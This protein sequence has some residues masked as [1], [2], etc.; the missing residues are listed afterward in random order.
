MGIDIMN[1]MP[2]TDKSLT[3]NH[4][5]KAVTQHKLWTRNGLQEHIFT[6]LFSGLV[7]AQIWEDPCI[8]MEALQLRGD[9]DVI[10]IASGG[11]N[12]MSYLSTPLRS[13]TAVDLNAHHIALNELKKACATHFPS[14]RYIYDFFART[15]NPIN[16]QHYNMFIA[17]YL[18][19]HARAYWE[20]KNIWGHKKIEC[21]NHN[22]YTHG[23][24]GHFI[25]LAHK[26]AALYGVSLKDIT[27]C[28]TLDEQQQFFDQKL[29]PIFR[30]SLFR[31]IVNRRASLY[32]LGIPPAQYKSLLSE[33]EDK[34]GMAY[35][36]EQRVERLACHLPLATNYFAW[37]A[38]ARHY[39]YTMPDAV[40]PY[41][42]PTHFDMIKSQTH[43]LS[44][45]QANLIDYLERARPHS[46]SCFVLLD[47]QDWMNDDTLNR[48][49]RAIMLAARPNARVIFRTADAP[50]L[51]THRLDPA[52]LSQWHYDEQ[53]CRALHARDRSAIYG[54]FHLYTL[55]A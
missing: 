33:G 37:Q 36:L 9:D 12:V 11:C 45:V 30:S 10:A 32:G 16:T 26:L 38:F 14:H 44:I 46:L 21:F 28:R 8:D 5:H 50:S 39:N 35:V 18:P 53:S 43:K 13:L 25:S 40:P 1:N 52:I 3:F 24:L 7:Y 48:L 17:P 51:L 22:F 47:A 6:M 54:G 41:L 34:G 31:F 19:K 49:W 20:Q 4:V 27:N 23:L 15:H 55:A 42:M 29:R 2:V